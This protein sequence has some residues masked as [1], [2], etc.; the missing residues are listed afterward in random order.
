MRENWDR[1]FAEV[2]KYEG[3]YVNHPKDPGGPTKF[4][5]TQA[6]LSQ[7]FGR[8]ATIAEVRALTKEA[9]KPIYKR[10]F[11]DVIRG[12]E[13][14]GGVD[15]ATF[16]FAVN[17]GVSRAARYLQSVVGV[18][19][20][21][22][23]G[24]ATIAAVNRYSAADV[25]KKLVAK[26]RG[27]LMGLRTWA[28]FGKGWNRRVVSVQ[29]IALT[30][31]PPS[32]GTAFAGLSADLPPDDPVADVVE[33]SATE[34]AS[35]QEIGDEQAAEIQSNTGPTSMFGT[36]SLLAS[37]VFWANTLGLLS[38]LPI[39]GGYL[40]DVNIPQFSEAMSAAIAAGAFI[41][42]TVARVYSKYQI[43]AVK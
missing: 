6:T 21:G 16:D 5:I 24:P 1:A 42:S 30:M 39:I 23:I 31:A 43:S 15:F 20:D 26:R 22:Q 13:L 34:R 14:P 32:T 35:N 41:A 37:K 2:I 11:W 33:V 4:G 25:V 8:A 28:S 9:V 36:K 27:F 19:Q 40:A 38:V 12:D 10:R 7:W 29:T 18:K 17:S 3:G